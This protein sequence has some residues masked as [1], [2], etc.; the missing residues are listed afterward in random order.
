MPN[1]LH[2]G[3]GL[4]PG[5]TL[6][7]LVHAWKSFSAK[8]ANR[9]L[10]TKGAFWQREYDD[11]LIRGQE[12]LEHAIRYVE[13]NPVKANLKHWKWV[14]VCGRDARTT[15]AKDGGATRILGS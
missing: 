5:E 6:A 15:A 14:W 4:F 8:E 12:E 1:H 13:E 2:V 10:G 9:I 7:A 11:H 3:V